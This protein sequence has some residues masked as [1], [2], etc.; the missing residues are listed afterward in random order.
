MDTLILIGLFA[1]YLALVAVDFLAPARA[2]PKVNNWRIKGLF[3][4]V[5]FNALGFVMPLV[6]DAFLAEHR[7]I[8]AS[9]LGLLPGALV[10]VL[11]VQLF[12][13]WWHRTM[14][15]VPFLWRW[16]HQ[17]H[18]SAERVDIFGAFYFSPLDMLGFLFMGSAAMVWA[19]GLRPEAAILANAS[20]TF[21]AFF[22]HANIKTPRWLGYFIQRPENHASHH[23]RGVHAGN[24]GDIPLWDMVFGTFKNP[25][26]WQGEAG[27]HDGASARMGQ[28]LLGRD[29][30]KQA[31]SPVESE[32]RRIF[33]SP[34]RS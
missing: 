7:L 27:F 31:S 12:S 8:D 22:Q 29:V 15:R 3:F 9:S 19:V 24:Y 6:W 34:A 10:G 30:S 13:Y 26:T 28:M 32:S 20:T 16:F 21:C 33:P 5:L 25:K 23:E 1:A 18:H 2:F 14:H 4:F 11:V 17:L